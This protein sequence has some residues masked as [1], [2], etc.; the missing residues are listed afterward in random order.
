MS[1]F[2]RGLSSRNNIFSFRETIGSIFDPLTVTVDD[3]IYVFQLLENLEQAISQF[4]VSIGSGLLDIDVNVGFQNINLNV[5]FNKL[6]ARQ[7]YNSLGYPLTS[8]GQYDCNYLLTL[9]TQHPILRLY[10]FCENE[11]QCSYCIGT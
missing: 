1:L 2:G 3:L 5:T 10:D 8:T 7:L 9:Y 4:Y 6:Y 11:P